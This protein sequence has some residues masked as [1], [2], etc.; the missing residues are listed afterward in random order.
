[1]KDSRLRPRWFGEEAAVFRHIGRLAR[2]ADDAPR[3]DGPNVSV[4]VY[5]GWRQLWGG[6]VNEAAANTSQAQ[7]SRLWEGIV[8]LQ[9]GD[10]PAI[11]RGPQYGADV[12]V[13]LTPRFGLVGGVGWIES[14]SMGRVIE[15][16]HS[17]GSSLSQSRS[18]A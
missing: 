1:M 10:A 18:S 13:H 15:T 17:P 8:P 16:P 4:H 14:S 12:T 6:D 5:G 9:D 11:R 3:T 2:T 7:V